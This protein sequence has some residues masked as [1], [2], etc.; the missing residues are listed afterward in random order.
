ME[1]R[2]NIVGPHPITGGRVG[3]VRGQFLASWV[4]FGRLSGLIGAGGG[5]GFVRLDRY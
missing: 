2:A 4:S 1:M 5:D 3:F